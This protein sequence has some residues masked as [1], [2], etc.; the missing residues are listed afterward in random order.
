MGDYCETISDGEATAEEAPELAQRVVD[1]LID[2]QIVDSQARKWLFA[3]SGYVPG[4]LFAKATSHPESFWFHYDSG[5]IV[6][7]PPEWTASRAAEFSR[8]PDSLNFESN[9]GLEVCLGRN[10]HYAIGS[11][12]WCPRCSFGFVEYAYDAGCET[13]HPD[14]E[15]HWLDAVKEWSEGG[16][17]GVT[18]PGCS[19]RT[20]VAELAYNPP[21][22]FGHLAFNFWNWGTLR[23]DFIRDIARILGH[24]IAVPYYKL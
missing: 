9:V 2:E 14:A 13:K 5:E 16:D 12:V 15:E 21:W 3:D 10:V 6:W 19:S 8:P 1:W 11:E 22:G 4:R 20:T 17:G 24:K 7:H 23:L 18:C